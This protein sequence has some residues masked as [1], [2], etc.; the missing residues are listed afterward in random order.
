[1][2]LA[3]RLVKLIESHSEQLS[4][5]LSEKVW[6]SPRCS[7]LHKVPVNELESRT[8]E[9]FRVVKRH[10]LSRIDGAPGEKGKDPRTILITSASPRESCPGYSISR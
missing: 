1:M 6:N 3:V 10:I 4:R 2:L 9:D 7:D 5:E 8:R